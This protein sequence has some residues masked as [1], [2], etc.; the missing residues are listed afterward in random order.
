VSDLRLAFFQ[1]VQGRT[2]R[3]S[4]K[5]TATK[6]KN[7]AMDA[8]FLGTP[9]GTGAAAGTITR[10][11][12]YD[13][14]AVVTPADDAS[15]IASTT[16]STNSTTSTNTSAVVAPAADSDIPPPLL[17]HASSSPEA[18]GIRFFKP[19]I[20]LERNK[21]R[22]KT[23]FVVDRKEQCLNRNILLPLDSLISFLEENFCCR[24]CRTVLR[25]DGVLGLE[26]FGAAC[27]LHF[28]CACGSK[29]SL[30]PKL[31]GGKED[32]LKILEVGRPFGARVNA[33]DFEINRRLYLGL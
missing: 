8:T 26:V 16:S 18:T 17:S 28:N 14:Y 20:D 31:V 25:G 22:R 1:N 3:R 12:S 15:S 11:S 19:E 7:S 10:S 32:K 2:T 6:N 5:K 13:C 27:G 21:S 33:G 4:R 23:S 29:G 30:L 9:T 24:Q